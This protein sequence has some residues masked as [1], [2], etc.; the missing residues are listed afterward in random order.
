MYLLAP[1]IGQ[2]LQ[3]NPYSQSKVMTAPHFWA[4]NVVFALKKNFFGKLIDIIFM[5]L[6]THFIMQNLKISLEQIQNYDT[7]LCAVFG[8]K[9]AQLL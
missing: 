9:T 1:F 4:Q 6:F 5:Y 7:V 2:N 8:T 3:K